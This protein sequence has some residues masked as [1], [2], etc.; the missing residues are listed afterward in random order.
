MKGNKLNDKVYHDRVLTCGKKKLPH[1]FS[2]DELKQLIATL[3][4]IKMVVIVFM[5]VFLG[6]RIGEMIKLKWSEVDF[7]GKIIKVLDGKNTK[8]YKSGY[9]KDRI[10]PVLDNFLNIL[11]SWKN[12]NPTEVYVI[13][14]QNSENREKSENVK[15]YL[16]VVRMFQKNFTK[17]LRSQGLLEV[18]YYQ[19][20]K[21]PRYKLHLHTLRHVCGCNLRKKGMN[22]EDIRDYLGHE[23]IETTQIYAELT[24][25][26]L[27]ENVYQAYNYP[28]QRRFQA[29]TEAMTIELTPDK[30]SLRLMNENLR[31]MMELR[32]QS[33]VIM[34]EYMP[35]QTL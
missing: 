20:N 18:D 24:K 32:K 8:R 9:G 17:Y 25:E 2:K 30:E 34:N 16:T 7:D 5:G 4:D 23:K 11:K 26:D 28:K 13:P 33:K 35:Q 19:K 12:I 14:Y 3:E 10:V 15:R 29:P 22:I 6:L 21:S 31:M 1:I 27:R